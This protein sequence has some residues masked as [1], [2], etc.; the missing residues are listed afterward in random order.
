MYLTPFS[1]STKKQQRQSFQKEKKNGVK[2]YL[3]TH[4]G[5]F[6]FRSSRSLLQLVDRLHIIQIQSINT[7]TNSITA[8]Q[9]LCLCK[10]VRVSM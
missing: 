3:S 9:L 2:S 8:S 1:D 4:Y 10:S 6:I 5:L 7:Y